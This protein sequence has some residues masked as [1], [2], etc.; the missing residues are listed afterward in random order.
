MIELGWR[1]K[2]K[3]SGFTGVAIARTEWL[4]GC[5]RIN[6]APEKSDK[7]GKPLDDRYIDEGQLELI[8]TDTEARAVYLSAVGDSD[9]DEVAQP[10]RRRGGPQ[11]DPKS[12]VG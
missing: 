6:V 1:V 4:N 9:F 2:D 3:I 12:P 11:N 10:I 5:I 8:T 7:D